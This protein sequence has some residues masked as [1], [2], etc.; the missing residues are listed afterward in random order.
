M[1]KK[2]STHLT[3]WALGTFFSACVLAGSPFA[4]ADDSASPEVGANGLV[5]TNTG[6]Q[7]HDIRLGSGTAAQLGDAVLVHYTGWLQNADG[8]RGSKFDSSRDRGQPFTFT[9]GQGQVIK[10]WEE[11]VR[12]MKVGGQ[13][14]LIIPSVLGYG[15][16]GAA[17]GMI[18]PNSTLIFEV[19]LIK[20]N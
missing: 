14:R 2:P 6:L 17:G 18:P 4:M 13:R 20:V 11:G 15:V 8:S 10:G 3:K 1:M 16:R 12:G 5:T 9:L 19:E 7:Y